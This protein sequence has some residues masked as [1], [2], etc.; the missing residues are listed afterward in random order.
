MALREL[1]FSVEGKGRP[2]VSEVANN[3]KM[4]LIVPCSPPCATSSMQSVR[5]AQ[6]R[7]SRVGL[8]AS[9]V[10]CERFGHVLTA[11]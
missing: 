2:R 11:V 3:L 1:T 4:V 8:S 5:V 10:G 7:L 6:V 9:A